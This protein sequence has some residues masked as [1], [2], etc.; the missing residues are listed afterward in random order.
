MLTT[1]YKAVFNRVFDPVADIL[2]RCG[3]GPSTVTIAGLIFTAASCAFL[4]ITH[5]VVAFCFLVTFA[6]LFDAFDGA[7]ARRSGR[8]TRFGAYLDAMVDRYEEALV[9]IAVAME[10]GYWL[11][12]MWLLTG[13]VLVSYAKAR[14]AMEA[15]IS[16]GE[17]P[18][19]MERMERDVIYVVGL[20]ISALVP[21]RIAGEDVFWWTL[22]VLCV[23]VHATVLQRFWRARALIA[24]RGGP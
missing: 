13:C 10:T 4:L 18:D 22:V 5:R 11:L 24:A 1:R 6:T 3:I 20:L 9:L 8:V 19:M 7:V 14:A 12:S 15:P 21:R 17:W 16:N 23:L 2:V